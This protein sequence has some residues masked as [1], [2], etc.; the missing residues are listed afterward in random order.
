MMDSELP[1]VA[2]LKRAVESGQRITAEDASYI[3]QREAELTGGGPVPGGPAGAYDKPISLTVADIAQ[4]LHRAWL[5]V[6]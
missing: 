1:S 5:C 6:R 2:E 3:G 4:Q